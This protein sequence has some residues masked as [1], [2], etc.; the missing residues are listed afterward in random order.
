[1]NKKLIIKINLNN[2]F[3]FKEIK[4]NFRKAGLEINEPDILKKGLSQAIEEYK[5]IIENY[6]N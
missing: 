6:N 3:K 2:K 4:K 1:M 5:K